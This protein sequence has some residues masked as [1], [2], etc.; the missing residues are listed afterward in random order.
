MCAVKNWRGNEDEWIKKI[1][2]AKKEKKNNQKWSK[3]HFCVS[4]CWKLAICENFGA[5][6]R[7]AT[8]RSPVYT[9]IIFFCSKI[10]EEKKTIK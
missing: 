9:N 1:E 4:L 10:Q 2:Q 8:A 7:L 3:Q 6:I 5:N